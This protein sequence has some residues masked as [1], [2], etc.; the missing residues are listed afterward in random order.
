MLDTVENVIE[1]PKERRC[2][3]ARSK[4]LETSPNMVGRVAREK[5][6]RR[7]RKFWIDGGAHLCHGPCGMGAHSGPTVPERSAA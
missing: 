4:R 6:E 3:H 5:V 2:A 1:A 7:S